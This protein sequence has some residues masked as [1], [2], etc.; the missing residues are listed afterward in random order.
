[1]QNMQNHVTQQKAGRKALL[2]HLSLLVL[3]I[4]P[5]IALYFLDAKLPGSTSNTFLPDRPDLSDLS[6]PVSEEHTSLHLETSWR[7][8]CRSARASSTSRQVLLQHVPTCC[9]HLKTTMD[10]NGIFWMVMAMSW[11]S[12]FLLVSLHVHDTHWISDPTSSRT[13]STSFGSFQRSNVANAT[14]AKRRH[15]QF[16]KLVLIWIASYCTTAPNH[17]VPHDIVPPCPLRLDVDSI[18][19]NARQLDGPDGQHAY[20]LKASLQCGQWPC[21]ETGVEQVCMINKILTRT[22]HNTSTI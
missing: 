12:V 8:G 14:W 6:V 16:F 17:D 7:N 15:A 10:Y 5:T 21:I 19:A 3:L 2:V 22:H 18:W 4:H 1:M 11:D 9:D 13:S 20:S